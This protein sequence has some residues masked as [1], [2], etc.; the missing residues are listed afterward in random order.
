MVSS[1]LCWFWG[2]VDNSQQI[3]DTRQEETG[4]P[5]KSGQKSEAL[6]EHSMHA[7]NGHGLLNCFATGGIKM[8]WDGSS[9]NDGPWKRWTPLKYGHF[10]YRHVRFWG[11]T[12]TPITSLL[13]KWPFPRWSTLDLHL[14]ELLLRGCWSFLGKTVKLWLESPNVGRVFFFRFT[15]PSLYCMHQGQMQ[16]LHVQSNTICSL[17]LVAN[18]RTEGS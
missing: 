8:W 3:D 15:L 9:T 12:G 5:G 7:S 10:W 13:H 2:I 6:V 4:R 18:G 14:L 17:S 16:K 1:L 11:C